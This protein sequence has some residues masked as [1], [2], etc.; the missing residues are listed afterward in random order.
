MLTRLDD[1]SSI[2]PAM[3]IALLTTFYG[4][5]LANMVFIPIASKLERADENHDMLNRLSIVA[6]LSIQRLENPRRLEMLIN[7]MLPPREQVRYFE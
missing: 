7:A 2:G 1:P 5:I 3:A 6:S 4:I